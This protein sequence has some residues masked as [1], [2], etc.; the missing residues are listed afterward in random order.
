MG[1]L[2]MANPDSPGAPDPQTLTR[3]PGRPAPERRRARPTIADVAERAGVSKGAVS[4]ALNGGPGVSEATRQRIIQVA[5]ELSWQPSTAARALSRARADAV[6]LVLNRPMRT[7]GAEPFFT[8]FISGLSAS[9]AGHGRGLQIFIVDSAADE[10]ATYQTWW[11]QRHVDAFVVMD[12][13]NDDPRIDFLAGDNVPSVVVGVPSDADGLS[14]VWSDDALTMRRAVQHLANLG[15]SRIAHVGG[16]AGLRHVDVRATA[17]AAACA[18]GGIEAITRKTDFTEA[19]A[20]QAAASLLSAPQA[21]TALIFDSDVMALAG[22]GVA[23]DAG[24]AVPEELSIVSLDDSVMVRLAHPAIT[25]MSRDTFEF[26]VTAGDAVHELL[27]HQHVVRLESPTPRLEV[28]HTSAPPPTVPTAGRRPTGPALLPSVQQHQQADQPSAGGRR[29]RSALGRRIMIA[30]DHSQELATLA[31]SLADELSGRPPRG[32]GPRRRATQPP[33]V[34]TDEPHIAGDIRLQLMPDDHDRPDAYSIVETGDADGRSIVLT[35][36]TVRGLFL[37]TRTLLQAID[38]DQPIGE[39]RD[40]PRFAERGVLL[41]VGRKYFS[42]SW[43]IALLHEMADLKLNTLQLHV[44]EGTGFGVECRTHPELTDGRQVLSQ[45]EVAEIIRVAHS[46]HIEVNADIDSPAHMDHILASHPDFRLQLADGTVRR[47]VLDFSI[48][49]AR[50]LVT[51]IIDEMCALI[52]GPVVHIGGDEVFPAPW[53]QADPELISDESAP[54]LAEYAQQVTGR[55]DATA[56]DGYACYLNSLAAHVRS[57]G[58]TARIWNDEVGP[59]ED[60]VVAIDSDVQID[61]WIRWN[62]QLP[63]AANSV[64]AGHQIVNSHGDYLYFILT[65]HGIG[66]GPNK[67]PRSIYERWTP[68]TFMGA[69]GATT[70]EILAETAPLLGAHL[71]VWCDTADVMTEDEIGAELSEWLQ[72]FAQQIWGGPHRYATW[73]ELRAAT[74]PWVRP[75]LS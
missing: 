9:L 70:D 59:R 10:L 45:A 21:P 25:A 44:S 29:R 13:V 71:S 75:R 3:T 64:E 60:G 36:A 6:G 49:Q 46:L 43:I 74:G 11:E 2:D 56:R 61:H 22:L 14:T 39:L 1:T 31:H 66:D 17:F 50:D 63:T 37:G 7:V 53:Q 58:R 54:Q 40:W 34:A 30:A 35:S 48:P 32:E 68:Y 57:I 38:Q 67:N 8:Q 52:D 47:D 41:D 55:P 15:H 16:I 73:A 26:G 18:D 4:F 65:P 51:E 20:A 27:D 28:R 69:A 12:P 62:R 5:E 23:L 19:V 33:V 24:I 42:P 72:A